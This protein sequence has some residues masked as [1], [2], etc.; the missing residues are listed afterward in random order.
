VV[1]GV[2]HYGV[3]NMPGA[4]PNTSTLALT[5]STL[6]YALAIADKG[7]QQAV[8]DDPALARGVNVADGKVTYAPVAE[9]HGMDYTPLEGLLA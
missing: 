2:L 4:V 3:A 6:R 1:D 7:W 5:N 8:A 9:A